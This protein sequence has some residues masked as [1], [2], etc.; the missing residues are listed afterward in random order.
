MISLINTETIAQ[1]VPEPDPP[2][3]IFLDTSIFFPIPDLTHPNI[4]TTTPVAYWL[5]TGISAS[6]IYKFHH[7]DKREI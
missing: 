3:D 5:M 7:P 6:I 4:E 2:P 1:K